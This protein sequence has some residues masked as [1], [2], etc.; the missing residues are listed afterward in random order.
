LAIDIGGT[1]FA[2]AV[3]AE[4]GEIIC[5]ARV[6]NPQGTDPELLF[7]AVTQAVATVCAA[8]DI[9]AAESLP[10]LGIG[11]ATAARIDAAAGTVSPVNI[12]AWR[13]FPLRD[14]L[15]QRYGLRV[16]MFGDAVASFSVV[17]Y[18]RVPRA[19]LGTSATSAWTRPDR[20]ACAA[21]QV[22]W[23]RHPS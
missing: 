5:S 2:A 15:H 20:S 21:Q 9:D 14:R 7:S 19:T 13:A 6:A 3:I 22:A 18:C 4:S 17:G 16:R 8:T 1:K 11:L 10:L 12:P 23:S